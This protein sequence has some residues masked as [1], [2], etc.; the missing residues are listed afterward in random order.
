APRGE[1]DAPGRRAGG[2]AAPARVRQ[3]SGGG[4]RGW[5]RPA[6]APAVG[7]DREGF[8]AGGFGSPSRQDELRH[9]GRRRMHRDGWPVQHRLDRPARRARHRDR[10]QGVLGTRLRARGGRPASRLRVPAAELATGVAG[11][12]FRERAGDPGLRFVRVRGG[13]PNA[14]ARLAGRALRGQRD[15]GLAARRVG[16]AV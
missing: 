16:R 4:A 10:G 1:S 5:G 9:R 12:T 11:G 2:P 14:G 13:G 6:G 7:A 8:R 15:H 3:R